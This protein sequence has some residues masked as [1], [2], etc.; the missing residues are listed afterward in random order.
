M[1]ETSFI[2][3]RPTRASFKGGRAI[4]DI[5]D[6]QGVKWI[7]KGQFINEHQI[8]VALAKG[9]LT[10]HTFEPH[11]EIQTRTTLLDL[12]PTYVEIVDLTSSI[13]DVELAK[14]EDIQRYGKLSEG[15]SKLIND[16]T[17]AIMT[18]LKSTQFSPYK[19]AGLT[20]F[21]YNEPSFK[22]K[23][24]QLK[25]LN[26]TGTQHLLFSGILTDNLSCLVKANLLNPFQILE[27]LA[28]RRFRNSIDRIS[29]VQYQQ[30]CQQSST[31]LLNSINGTTLENKF[32]K[33]LIRYFSPHL[34]FTSPEVRLFQMIN[35][36]INFSLPSGIHE[37]MP[38]KL[39]D[40]PV[41]NLAAYFKRPE[42]GGGLGLEGARLVQYVGLIPSGTAIQFENR[43]KGVI[44]APKN[45]DTLYCAVITGMDGQPMI[46]PSLRELKFKNL[47][48]GYKIIPSY[49]LPLKYEEH[50]QE[51]IWKMHI[52]HENLKRLA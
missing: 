18:L 3:K 50:S 5:F 17:D 34:Y 12:K 38:F 15:T 35:Q 20:S 33:D 30:L 49:D 19:L 16:S 8:E 43:E 44:I 11:R 37:Q 51:K 39:S 10:S 1:S 24:A 36:Y 29:Q 7:A 4:H 26:N 47:N 52:V 22:S 40:L 25:L 41:I 32:T 21:L 48:I 14:A 6:S 42:M 31:Q 28:E 9:S 13:N 23:R 46:S 45:K 2:T 27:S